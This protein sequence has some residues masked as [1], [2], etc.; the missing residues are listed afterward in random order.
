[1]CNFMN[2]NYFLGKPRTNLFPI[3]VSES[4]RHLQANCIVTILNLLIVV[5]LYSTQLYIY[6]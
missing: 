1:M 6:I 4:L 2:I 3:P 5:E